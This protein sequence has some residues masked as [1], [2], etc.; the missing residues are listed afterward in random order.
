MSPISLGRLFLFLLLFPL[1]S[2]TKNVLKG[3]G[4]ITTEERTVPA[5]TAV[6]NSGKFRI[7]LQQAAATS[8]T[9][10]GEDNVL[11][12]IRT[13]VVNNMLRIYYD[14]N[15]TNPKHQMVVISI[16]APVVNRLQLQTDGSIESIGTWNHEELF[17]SNSGSGEIRW[18]AGMESLYTNLSGSGKLLLKG[19]VAAASHT[20]SGS[21]NIHSFELL[22]GE[23][24]ANV[25]GSGDLELSARDALRCT[26]S[27]SGNIIFKG[28]PPVF[29]QIISGSGKVIRQ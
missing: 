24:D 16:A 27:G 17:V 10:T 14:R 4:R 11:P 2:C 26:I 3:S 12:E 22:S 15:N 19:E 13:E 5:F 1:V 8:I 29:S 18:E 25:S 7:L 23:S 21:G 6:E 9:M 20:I 28:D